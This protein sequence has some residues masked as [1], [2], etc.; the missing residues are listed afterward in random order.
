[1]NLQ[2]S[3]EEEMVEER[4]KLLK[5]EIIPYKAKQENLKHVATH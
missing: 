3:Y 1:M 2:R 4:M 5:E